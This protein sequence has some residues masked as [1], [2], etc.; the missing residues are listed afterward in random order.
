MIIDSHY[1]GSA[2]RPFVDWHRTHLS[3]V[4]RIVG[5]EAARTDPHLADY[6]IEQQSAAGTTLT[7]A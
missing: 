6:V 7:F 3:N 2:Y 4:R 1:A 5:A